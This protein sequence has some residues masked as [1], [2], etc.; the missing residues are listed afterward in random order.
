MRE[1][2]RR[3]ASVALSLGGSVRNG[4]RRFHLTQAAL[5]ERIAVDQ[6]RISQIERGEGAG[7]PLELWVALGVALNMPLAIGFSR[8]LGEM[9]EPTD[10]G[11]LAMQE[12]LLA[13]ARAT[14]R[15]TTFELPTRPADPRRSIDVCVG[16]DPNRVLIINEAWNTFGDLGA[17]IRSTNRKA[18]ETA[19]LAAVVDDG[20]PYRV[21]TVWVV[22]PTAA[23]RALIARYPQIFRSAF[24][25]SS[26]AWMRALTLGSAPPVEAGLVWLDPR[27]GRVTEWRKPSG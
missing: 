27:S 19:D 8:P 6:T 12:R 7:V 2:S 22:R 16:D 5:G 13:L 15:R 21:A 20:P 9:R 25:G 26:R 11:H 4:R 18:A 3:T 17:A 24:P 10:A 1:A 23:N 14:G